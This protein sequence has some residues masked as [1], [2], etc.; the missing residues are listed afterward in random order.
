MLQLL[1][2]LFFYFSLEGFLFIN[3]IDKDSIRLFDEYGF[4]NMKF[5]FIRTRKIFYLHVHKIDNQK[6][7]FVEYH[8]ND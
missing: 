3:V 7:Y 6:T 4:N 2:L 5:F 8:I 1:K